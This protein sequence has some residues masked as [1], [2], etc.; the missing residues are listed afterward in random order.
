MLAVM[1]TRGRNASQTSGDDNGPA[2]P[3]SPPAHVTRP[4]GRVVVRGIGPMGPAERPRL[5]T[6]EFERI[7]AFRGSRSPR[8]LHGS[9]ETRLR[10]SPAMTCTLRV[11]APGDHQHAVRTKYCPL[12]FSSMSWAIIGACLAFVGVPEGDI[13]GGKAIVKQSLRRIRRAGPPKREVARPALEPAGCDIQAAAGARV[14]IRE[15]VTP[16]AFAG[17]PRPRARLP[18]PLR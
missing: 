4:G 11:H 2:A 8:R 12:S 16:T 1:R 17:V 6:R 15:R 5:G 9:P 13:N 3:S 18:P 7:P 10:G 14:E